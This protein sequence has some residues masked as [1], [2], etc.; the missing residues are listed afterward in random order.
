MDG[1]GLNYLETTLKMF[2]MSRS[3]G[4]VDLVNR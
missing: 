4:R 1:R 3:S 2:V